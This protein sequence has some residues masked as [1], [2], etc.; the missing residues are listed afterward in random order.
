MIKVG[1]RVKF[2]SD[3]G[4]GIVRSIKGTLAYVEVEDGFEIP[5][6]L[7]D[8]VEVAIE[9]ENQ[10]IVKIGPDEPRSGSAPAGVKPVAGSQR[11][12]TNEKGVKN[13][14][15]ISLTDEYE[16]E[17]IDLSLLKKQPVVVVDEEPAPVV[18]LQAPWEQDEYLVKLL[19]VPVSAD[20]PAE[21]SDLEMFIVNDSTY[22]VYYYVG[23]RNPRMGYL[24]TLQNG[25]LEA[26]TKVSI[27]TFKRADMAEVQSLHIG[28][29]PFKPTSFT[30]RRP[31]S[32]ELELHPLK[33]VRS[34]SYTEN[35]Y[36]DLPAV[37]YTL[38]SDSEQVPAADVFEKIAVPEAPKK[39]KKVAN[40]EVIDLHADEILDNPQGMSA[41]EIL[42]AQ[43]SRFTIS[44]DG[45]LRAGA[46]GPK[47]MVFIHGV[48]KG[49]LRYELEKTLKRDYPKLRYQDASF[50]E[51]GY[52][53]I[54][55]FVR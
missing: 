55:V 52:G 32:F 1:S 35:D 36:F 15:R 34:G 44:L 48:G 45:A 43:L 29:L 23:V 30:L 4:V 22:S 25:T 51:Y 47:K 12:K 39:P 37:E 7:T 41:T 54:L 20:K 3:T 49:K 42:Q 33:F 2:I 14:G 16:D 50:A 8:I 11:K 13:Y 21:A 10:A 5:A 18:P 53:A 17:P 46:A 40:Q 31:D 9:Q 27:K 19:F 38:A 28:L 26:D 6:L 24:T